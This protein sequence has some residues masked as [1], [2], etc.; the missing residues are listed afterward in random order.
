M[1]FTEL[2]SQCKI[3]TM[4][5]KTKKKEKEAVISMRT[6]FL[7]LKP[8]SS[9]RNRELIQAC[10][11]FFG[12]AE[13]GRHRGTP[14]STVSFIFLGIERQTLTYSSN[15]TRSPGNRCLFTLSGRWAYAQC[16]YS[17]GSCWH[18]YH[19]PATRSAVSQWKETCITTSRAGRE[20]W[21]SG[22][23]FFFFFFFLF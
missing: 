15:P 1:Q 22:S 19:P 4:T 8:K 7:F 5:I 12:F 9:D 11:D 14:S 2:R 21:C 3:R 17:K 13:R 6:F 23:S 16:L 20:W 18:E 10:V